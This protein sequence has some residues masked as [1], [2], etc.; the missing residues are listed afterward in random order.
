[1][2]EPGLRLPP[3]AEEWGFPRCRACGYAWGKS[4]EEVEHIVTSAPAAYAT[5]LAGRTDAKVK[6]DERTWSPSGYVWHLSDWLRIQGGRIYGI[7]HD[8]DFSSWPVEPDDI[9]LLFHYDELSTPAG[10]WI[11][12]R[13]A[14]IFLAAIAGL[15]AELTFDHPVTGEMVV[16]DLVRYVCHEVPHHELD[17]KRGLGAS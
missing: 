6:P 7:R 8:P 2:S 11:L 4:L 5:L 16:M 9:D 17:I 10:L 3:G 1:M 15:E 12:E 14:D 13:S